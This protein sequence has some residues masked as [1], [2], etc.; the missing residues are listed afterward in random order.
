MRLAMPRRGQPPSLL[1]AAGQPVPAGLKIVLTAA[2]LAEQLAYHAAV[3]LGTGLKHGREAGIGVGAAAGAQAGVKA[4]AQAGVI[5]GTKVGA[6][7]GVKLGID[8][9]LRSTRVRRRIERDPNGQ[10]V[11][12]IEER[13]P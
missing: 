7:A 3:G 13:V 2:E 1:D 8:H 4:G 10:I 12:S 11:G 9:A 5:A 6:Q